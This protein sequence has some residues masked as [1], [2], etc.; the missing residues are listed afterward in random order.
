MPEN[1][2]TEDKKIIK[3]LCF[4]DS[5]A[6]ATGFGRVAEG[7]FFNLAQT[8]RYDI[9]IFGINDRG[10]W[11][12]P[13]KYPYRIFP[14][15]RMGMQD[16][17]GRGRFLNIIR[18][19]DPDLKP[20]WD[21][22]FFLQDPFILEQPLVVFNRGMMAMID[23][24]YKQY[25]EKARPE[26]WF[27]TVYYI[28]IDSPIK[29]NW[30]KDAIAYANYQIAYTNYGKEQIER[31][32]QSLTKPCELNL[33]VIYHGTNTEDF[34]PV[35]EKVKME[36]K[37]EF[38]KGKVSQ[39]AFII[40]IVARN[41]MRKD[42]PRAMKIFREFQKRRP[43][44][45]LYIHAKENDSWGSLM[46]YARN[47]DL[48]LGKDWTFPKGFDENVGFPKEALNLLYN[49]SDVHLYTTHGEGFGLPITESM[50]TKTINVAPNVTSIPEI[51]NSVGKDIEL[52]D[53]EKDNGLR[54]IPV[55]SHSTT[56]EWV[57]YGPTDYERIRPLAN[58]DD[59]VR[60]LIWV[61]DNP[62]KAKTIAEK[63]HQW[64][65]KYTWKEIANQWDKLFQ[66]VY[67][68]LEIERKIPRVHVSKKA[69][70]KQNRPERTKS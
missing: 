43:D 54:G 60:K 48:E 42:I 68:A 31:A 9:D 44:S 34:Y 2:K 3:M 39:D 5:P 13:E 20:P 17:Y 33:K 61:Y 52:E 58:V 53:I 49:I 65:Q 24:F 28:P 19:G 22:I 63:G 35:E 36:F 10:G 37:R 59:A 62:D 15:T 64:I 6:C 29:A 55:K 14:A 4:I 7:I 21:I 50:A 32:N 25:R 38:F 47:F 41:Q 12:D 8:G 27:K 67:Q 16:F 46:E 40:S 45:F 18:G 30:V 57:T 70:D 23:H 66:E 56:S 1:K 51:F 69:S 26:Q 11:K